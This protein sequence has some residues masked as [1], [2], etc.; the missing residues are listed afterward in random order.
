VEGRG[1]LLSPPLFPALPEGE[2]NQALG[3]TSSG[4]KGKGRKPLGRKDAWHGISKMGTHKMSNCT[5][6]CVG[7]THLPKISLP[8]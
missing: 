3:D 1:D 4:M 8:S 7:E 5:L 2:E 6:T